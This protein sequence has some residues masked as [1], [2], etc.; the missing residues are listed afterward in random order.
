[1]ALLRF[2]EP[3]PQRTVGLVWRRSSPRK[4]DFEAL[5]ACI[6]EALEPGGQ[7][8]L[9]PVVGEDPRAGQRPDA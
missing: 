6:L 9:P 3:Q 7:P 4:R 5:G 1:V 8:L 2:E